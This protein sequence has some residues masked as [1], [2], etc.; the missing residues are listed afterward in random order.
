MAAKDFFEERTDES[1]IKALIVEQY[2]DA[3][4]RVMMSVANRYRRVP[5]EI[6]YIDLFA[7]PGRYKDG[8]PSTPILILRKAIEDPGLCARLITTFTDRDPE[9]VTSLREAIGEIPGIDGLKHKPAIYHVEVDDSLVERF[10]KTHLVPALIFLDPWGIKGL[11][12]RL[13]D[14][15]VKDWG[16]DCILFFNYNRV[17]MLLTQAGARDCVDDLFGQPRAVAL[18]ER[19]KGLDRAA[20]EQ[21]IVDA[22]CTAIKERDGHERFILPFRFKDARGNRTKHHLIFVT[23]DFLGYDI[24]KGIMARL[25]SSAEQGVATLEFDRAYQPWLIEPSQPLDDLADML[26]RD[27]AGQTLTKG[28][29]YRQHSVDRRYLR[30]DYSEVLLKLERDGRISTEDPKGK[31][32][33]NS[34]P[35]RVLVKFPDP[36]RGRRKNGR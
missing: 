34:F 29:I 11:S 10:E 19:V 26:L 36:E 23:K 6:A 18:R 31:R 14:A 30:R 1:R 22:L 4:A 24:M 5:A 20:R 12:L 32:R 25:S 7:G 17:N 3:W 9:H 21:A 16:C 8:K 33:K 2:F 13:I 28:D 15:V 27:F 35:D